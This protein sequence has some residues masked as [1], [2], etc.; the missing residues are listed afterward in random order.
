MTQPDPNMLK[1]NTPMAV[2]LSRSPERVPVTVAPLQ[3]MSNPTTI[4]KLMGVVSHTA[5]VET[6]LF[7]P[8]HDN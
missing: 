5:T 6:T 1:S 2:Q 3:N 4:E 8:C 7:Y